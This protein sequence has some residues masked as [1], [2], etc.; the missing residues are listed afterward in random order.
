MEKKGIASAVDWIIAMGIFLVYFGLVFVF[1]KPGV[2]ET[3]DSQTL[4]DLVEN[5]F[6][7]NTTWSMTKT[8]I[9]LDAVSHLDENSGEK[10]TWKNKNKEVLLSGLSEEVDNLNLGE[11]TEFFSISTSFPEDKEKNIEA[12]GKKTKLLKKKFGN[13]PYLKVKFDEDGKAKIILLNSDES[14]TDDSTEIS[15]VNEVQKNLKLCS[16]K[17]YKEGDTCGAKYTVGASESLKGISYS[18]FGI[19]RGGFNLNAE[20]LKE[21]W[22]FPMI[23]EFKIVIYSPLFGITFDTSEKNTI[24]NIG[25]QVPSLDTQVYVREFNTFVLS[26]DGVKIPVT[27]NIRVW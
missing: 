2:S 20:S 16:S 14:L 6:V 9:F 13:D 18:K 27:I 11:K 1:F 22:G 10:I 8:P 17:K 15:S 3:F 19:L 4:L 5:K 24:Y 23:K 7:E 12:A 21:K 25:N 26:D